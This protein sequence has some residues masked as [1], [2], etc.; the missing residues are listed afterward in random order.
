M[1]KIEK[2]QSKK[3]KLEEL[4]RGLMQQLLTGVKKE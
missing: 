2:E 4:K 3:D 1:L